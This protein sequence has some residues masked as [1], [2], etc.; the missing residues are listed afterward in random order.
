[1]LGTPRVSSPHTCEHLQCEIAPDRETVTVIARGELDLA[2][3]PTLDATLRELRGAGFGSLRIDLRWLEFIDVLGVDLLRRWSELGAIEA[4][5]LSV[6]VAP[7]PVL[8]TVRLLRL[9]L[10][11]RVG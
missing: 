9:P 11:A 3:V 5:D 2:S 7:G 8:R 1:M 10:R 6:T 4:F